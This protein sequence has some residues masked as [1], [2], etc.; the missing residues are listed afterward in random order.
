MWYDCSKAVNELGFEQ[1]PIEETIRKDVAWFRMKGWSDRV[2][3]HNGCGPKGTNEY[4]SR[5]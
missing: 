1:T 2:Q 5:T 4:E 3:N